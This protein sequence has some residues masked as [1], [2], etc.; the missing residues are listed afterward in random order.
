MKKLLLF[1]LTI[2]LMI[3]CLASCV[4]F[5]DSE[6]TTEEPTEKTFTYGSFSITLPKDFSEV[7]PLSGSSLYLTSPDYTV[8]IYRVSF[9]SITPNEGYSFPTL[10]EFFGSGM[11]R[12]IEKDDI[13]K[14]DGLN[15]V[16]ADSE[17]NDDLPDV[18][19]ILM[20][21]ENAFW[22]I[23]VSSESQP[24][25]MVKSNAI[26]WAKTVT[27]SAAETVAE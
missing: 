7:S 5:G 3:S 10:E 25:E 22:Q 1:A 19:Y 21:S 26:T 6:E 8:Q 17:G 2:C 13:K 24:Y 15:I 14:E 11:F 12:D 20:E 4:P 9:S 27:F 16:D 23:K 18:C